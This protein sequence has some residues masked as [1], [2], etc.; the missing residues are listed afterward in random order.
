[1]SWQAMTWVL[2]ESESSMSARLVLIAIASHADRDGLK[3]FPS[4]DTLARETLLSRREVIYS[5]Q[6]LEELGEL[7][8]IRGIG[9]GNP[10]QY[11]L[12]KV[13][14]WLLDKEI[15]KKKTS[16]REK[17]QAVHHLDSQK[18][19]SVHQFD[20]EKVQTEA[21]KVQITT[22]KGAPEGGKASDGP[23]PENKELDDAKRCK[24]PLENR[25]NRTVLTET[26]ETVQSLDPRTV[27]LPTVPKPPSQAEQ[28]AKK[29]RDK[30]TLRER[31]F[32]R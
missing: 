16:H 27:Q 1:M 4:L 10:N 11:E 2:E 7:R 13:A 12:P 22:I 28:W 26:P 24:E 18:V 31:G 3:A 17:V 29:E 6:T 15:E 20:G 19:Q 32:L 30:Q 25:P 14:R 23:I 8:V 5:V 21:E 9:R